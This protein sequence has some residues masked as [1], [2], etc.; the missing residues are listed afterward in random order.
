M[1]V[2]NSYVAQEICRC[3]WCIPFIASAGSQVETAA[4]LNMGDLES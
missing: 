1:D 2:V 3:N 4:I